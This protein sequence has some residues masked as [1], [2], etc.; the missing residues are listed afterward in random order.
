MLQ[1]FFERWNTV[2]G[3]EKE[4]KLPSRAMNYKL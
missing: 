1:A 4:A 3:V 2:S